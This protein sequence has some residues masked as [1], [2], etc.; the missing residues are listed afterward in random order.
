MRPGRTWW[1]EAV[2]YQVYVRSF[3]DSNGDGV[4]DLA[5]VTSRLGYL[6]WL[7]VDAIWLT[8]F[9]TSTQH[10]LGY[11]ITDYLDVDP[12]HGCLADFDALVE[13]AHRLDIKVILDLVA[14]HT[15]IEHPWF[16]ESRTSRRSPKR[17]WYWWRPGRGAGLPPNNWRG[18]VRPSAG[19]A[20]VHDEPTDEWYLANFSPYQPE[21]NWA[22]P[23]VR[24]AIGDVVAFWS[25]RGA[26]GFRIDMVDFL[27]KD[28]ELTDDEDRPDLDPRDRIVHARH[29]LNRPES[30]EYVR[31]LRKYLADSERQVLI[32]ELIYHSP[33]TS[34]AN[35]GA[36]GVLDL[37]LNFRLTY[38]DFD[39]PTLSAFI[40]DYEDACRATG[41]WP[42]YCL[43]NH[44]SPRTGRL[45]ARLRAALLILLTLRGTPF[46]YY[47]DELGM[48]NVDV[49]V[50]DR[51]DL[52]TSGPRDGART[53]MPWTAEPGVGFTSATARPWLP[54][55]QPDA[56]ATVVGQTDDPGSTLRLV[57]EL[58][59]LR[60]D[61][62][63]LRDG[64]L[65]ILDN[66]PPELLAFRRAHPDGHVTVL[67]NLSDHP[68]TTGIDT[69]AARIGTHRDRD[70][71]RSDPMV[72]EANEAIVM[73][74]DG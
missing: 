59:R 9:F 71:Y 7:G 55:G 68:V 58:L 14:N 17:D 36:P 31:K 65:T 49:S 54:T 34:L 4:G 25:A 1:R 72:L 26:D 18:Q 2:V 47:G 51:Q 44:D 19:G 52:W 74:G 22:N 61:L 38:L 40:R 13:E 16:H 43:G 70:G 45:G 28:P 33:T 10:D 67:A 63:A 69:S 41:A 48:A 60:R 12:I 42:T 23:E 46:L 35:W 39:A 15:S 66:T 11:D 56:A 30:L 32:G 8:P 73:V 53:P 50:T 29:Q 5:G 20:W 37:P 24:A 62:P 57:R 64:N 6:R 3:A 27:G 21:L